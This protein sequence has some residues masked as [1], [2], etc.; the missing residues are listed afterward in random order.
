MTKRTVPNSTI[1]NFSSELRAKRIAVNKT[2]MDLMFDCAAQGV[3][4]TSPTD[5]SYLETGRRVPT[6]EQ[7]AALQKILGTFFYTPQYFTNEFTSTRRAVRYN[8]SIKLTLSKQQKEK[9]KKFAASKMKPMNE[10]L[11]SH[12]DSL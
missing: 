6:R 2:Q 4:F 11:R 9:L 7:F 5:M 1:S 12:I 10:I 3:R 8:E